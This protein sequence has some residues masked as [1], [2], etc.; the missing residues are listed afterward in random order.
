GFWLDVFKYM[1]SDDIYVIFVK[2][3]CVL[4]VYQ[5]VIDQGGEPISAGEYFQNGNVTEFKYSLDLGRVFK[6]GQ[7]AW[8]SNF[9]EGWAY[10]ASNKAVVF[11]DNHDN[12]RGHGGGGSVLT[13][14][15][16]ALYALGNV[17]ML[18]HPYGTPSLMSSF[19]F[20]DAS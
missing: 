10:M 17:F 19:D 6:G 20:S 3:D 4:F 18:A 7:L 5:E 11:T 8:L 1:V 14:K 2:F 15:D 13:Y 16:G 9:G 12:Q